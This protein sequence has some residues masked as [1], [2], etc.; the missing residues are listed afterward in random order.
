LSGSRFERC[1]TISFPVLILAR[2]HLIDIIKDK[3]RARVNPINVE[4]A[5]EQ[6][7]IAV[8]LSLVPALRQRT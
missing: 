4:S 5:G 7:A 8:T 1:G 2:L 6:Q 3:D